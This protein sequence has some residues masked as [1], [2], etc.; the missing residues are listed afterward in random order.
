MAPR[1]KEQQ[2]RS[3]L[4]ETHLITLDKVRPL[5]C[6][7]LPALWAKLDYFIFVL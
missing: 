6:I 5:P 1:D 4:K 7:R 2:Q 3:A